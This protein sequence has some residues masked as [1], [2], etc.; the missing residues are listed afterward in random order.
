ME[1]LDLNL[2]NYELEDLLNLFK[3]K[4]DFNE[5]ELKQAKTMAL[6]THPD[7]SRLDMKFFIFFKKAYN[8]IEQIYNFR[9]KKEQ[10]MFNTEYTLDTGDVTEEGEKELLKKLDGKNVKDFNEWFN[11]MFEKTRVKNKEND[12]GYGKWFK[13]DKDVD[14]TKVS[15]TSEFGRYFNRRK[16]DARALILHEGVRE[17]GSNVGYSLNRNNLEEYSSGVFSKL[18]YEDLKKAHTETV[19]PV[20]NEDFLNRK[21]Y[22]DVDALSQ[23]RD[24]QDVTAISLEQSKRLLHEKNRKNIVMSTSTAYDLLKQDEEARRAN[25]EWWKHLKQLEYRKK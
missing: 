14:S 20:T 1:Q 25:K 23:A 15:S 3:L 18:A 8:R 4:I 24:R 10:D 21:R 17:N 2:E 12:S 9:R 13:S 11:K 16:Q 19:V 22:K 7:K 5:D 6:K